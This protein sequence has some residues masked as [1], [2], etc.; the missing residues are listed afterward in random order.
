MSQEFDFECFFPYPSVRKEQADAIS[1]ALNA[2]ASEGLIRLDDSSLFNSLLN[3]LISHPT[4]KPF[5]SGNYQ[6]YNETDLIGPDNSIL[7]PDRLCIK[8]NEAVIIDYKTGSI[9]ES[10]KTQVRTYLNMVS[11]MGY[12]KVMGFL[13][14]T[15]DS[16]Q[17]IEV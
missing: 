12:N 3:T 6:I 11:A 14:Y 9:L 17:V 8:E 15:N 2:I 16:L 4:L 13:V 5:F 1:F 7:R 10:H